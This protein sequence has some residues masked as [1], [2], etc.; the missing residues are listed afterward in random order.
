LRVTNAGALRV[1]IVSDI[2]LAENRVD[3]TRALKS[4]LG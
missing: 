4:D 3:R 2:L 1:A